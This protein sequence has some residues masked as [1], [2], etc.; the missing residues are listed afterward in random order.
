M[1]SWHSAQQST[2]VWLALS[3]VSLSENMTVFLCKFEIAYSLRLIISWMK[4][5]F[6]YELSHCLVV[7]VWL[8]LC[9]DEVAAYMRYVRRLDF[10]ETPDYQFL[11]KLFTDLISKNGWQCDWE[12]DWVE[13]Q[14]VWNLVVFENLCELT[15]RRYVILNFSRP[16]NL[17]TYTIWIRCWICSLC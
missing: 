10:F 8:H 1:I 5:I 9:A 15:C 6:P 7:V 4:N 16:A 13:R 3:S 2:N 11:V 12:F 14:S 17:T